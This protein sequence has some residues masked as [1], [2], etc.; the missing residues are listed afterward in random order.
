[1]TS[2]AAAPTPASPS[3]A[4]SRRFAPVLRRCACGGSGG[5]TGE[6]EECRKK[7]LQRSP[8]S[9]SASAA[10]SAPAAVHDVLRSPAQAL[11]SS[12]R[13]FMEPRF[14]HSFANVRVHADATA[15]ESASA[16]GARAY[17]VGRDVVFA[18]GRYAPASP[19]GRKL[20][21][22]EL[23]HVVQQSGSSST[24]LSPSLEIGPVD[25]PEE[26]EAD[27]V[28]ASIESGGSAGVSTVGGGMTL[29]RAPEDAGAP[30]APSAP[31]PAPAGPDAGAP[32]AGA[33]D[34]GAD[35]G[36]APSCPVADKGTLS[37]VSWGETG[38]L[39][40]TDK[41]G[42]LYNPA[43]W[44]AAKVCDI[45]TMRAGVH[46]VGGR[47]QSV[48]KASPPA[49]DA[50]AQSIKKYHFVENFPSADAAV[51]DTEVKWF[52]LSNAADTPAS[53]PSVP[54]STKVKSYGSFYNVGGGDVPKGATWVHF[55]KK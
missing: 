32:D 25:A 29:A 18:S 8:S 12:T 6:C 35:A 3:D 20:L 28:A 15:A 7:R 54:A 22:H 52:Y 50:F 13:A 33:P 40:P 53:H 30:P 21:A 47:G 42:S 49:G 14:G 2:S 24:A 27:A 9:P 44:D 1:M 36:A 11:D 55:Y 51:A 38:G 19:E 16:M 34:A 43:K 31:A 45:L 46:L 26:R 5:P 17:T 4:A 48:H 23:T 37:Q 39:Y 10:E 41:A